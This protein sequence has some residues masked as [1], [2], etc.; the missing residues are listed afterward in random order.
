MYTNN[1]INSFSNAKRIYLTGKTENTKEDN[2]LPQIQKINDSLEEE[3]NDEKIINIFKSIQTLWDDLGVSSEYKN[4]FE[5]YIFNLN[6]E[7]IFHY[8]NFEKIN[9]KRYKENIVKLSKEINIRENNIKNLKE[10]DEF[11]DKNYR[12]ENKQLTQS[13]IKNLERI[14]NQLRITSINIINYMNTIQEISS[15]RILKGKYTLNKMKK[16]FL[17]N[18]DYLKKMIFD[19]DFLKNS[20]LFFYFKTSPKTQIDTF[21]TFFSESFII[22][23]D[24]L[25]GIYQAKYIL[26]ENNLFNA[27]HQDKKKIFE[28]KL[29]LNCLNN[30][31]NSSK[32]QNSLSLQE[33]K[34]I[35]LKASKTFSLNSSINNKKTIE[36][37]SFVKNLRKIKIEKEDNSKEDEEIKLFN[38]F[39]NKKEKE[40]E[41][42]KKEEK[43]KKK[44]REEEEKKLNL[45]EELRKIIEE[46][47]KKYKDYDLIAQ[48]AKIIV[49]D[50]FYK[51]KYLIKENIF[52][53]K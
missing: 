36:K 50:L 1:K 37:K 43:M 31:F 21:F 19:L 17:Y 22:G 45:N 44:L 23:K 47:I 10:L 2:F 38:E 15:F 11:I 5:N 27:I 4:K 3:K 8:L 35:D 26:M 49:D 52:L 16:D 18:K 30:S 53:K 13:L 51:N 40:I 34:N 28:K 25:K 9:L 33:K 20:N 39:I 14:I 24:L 42:I 32:K 6:E 12:R 48:R 41:K 46:E 7:E 29:N